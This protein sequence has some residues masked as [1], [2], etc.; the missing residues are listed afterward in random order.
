MSW[1]PF[2]LGPDRSN[3]PRQ[4]WWLLW[5]DL[6]SFRTEIKGHLT[7]DHHF[8]RV[9]W[10]W[11]S[12]RGWWFVNKGTS[13]WKSR[14]TLSSR[15]TSGLGG[16]DKDRIIEVT[17]IDDNDAESVHWQNTAGNTCRKINTR[18]NVPKVLGNL[19]WYRIPRY[20]YM[21]RT[22]Y[23]RR[24]TLSVLVSAK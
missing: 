13:S 22:L 20:G 23:T 2:W 15:R 12:W 21:A 1:D 16:E 6:S 8:D 7:R 9:L 14:D 10:T 18:Y 5:S 24:P 19:G 4:L 3:L 11:F 17:D